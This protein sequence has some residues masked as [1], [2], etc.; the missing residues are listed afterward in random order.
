M[1]ARLSR[2][3]NRA[4]VEDAMNRERRTSAPWRSSCPLHADSAIERTEDGSM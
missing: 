2:R 4:I 1:N 3:I